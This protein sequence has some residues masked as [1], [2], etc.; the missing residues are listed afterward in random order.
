MVWQPYLKTAPSANVR[1]HVEGQVR[2]FPSPPPK[3]LSQTG[4]QDFLQPVDFQPVQ[5]TLSHSVN[6]WRNTVGFQRMAWGVATGVRIVDNV[7]PYDLRDPIHFDRR[8]SVPMWRSNYSRP[9]TTFD[10][11]FIPFHTPAR[12]PAYGATLMPE[13]NDLFDAGVGVPP[14]DIREATGT[15]T[16]VKVTPGNGQAAFRAMFI[17][18]RTDLGISWTNG[19]DSLPQASGTFL[20]T[21]FQT[22]TDRVDVGVPFEYPRVHIVGLDVKSQLPGSVLTW[23]EVG[24]F[25]PEETEVVADEAQINGLVALGALDNPPDTL[26]RVTTQD[27]IPY[28]R[29]IIGAER[30]VGPFYLNLQWLHGFPTE[31]QQNEL[32]DYALWVVHINPI[33]EI[34]IESSGATDA[35]GLWTSAGLLGIVDDSWEMGLHGVW[36]DGPEASSLAAMSGARQIRFELGTQY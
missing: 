33:P 15:L 13:A 28:L 2:L 34:R 11:A 29:W 36:I 16:P 22:D 32:N 19:H 9:Q 17:G 25:L 18:P 20:L 8:L 6:H 35:Q 12:L 23:A 3:T 4:S 1:L 30:V 27:G 5:I 10:F 21:G 14:L 24:L 7:N 26:P 31:R